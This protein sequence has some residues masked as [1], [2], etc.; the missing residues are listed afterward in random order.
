[1]PELLMPHHIKFATDALYP[2]PVTDK[3][4]NLLHYALR[5]DLANDATITLTGPSSVW[6]GVG[7]NASQMAVLSCH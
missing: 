7:F 6:F 1:M 3:P 2:S 4:G 5:V